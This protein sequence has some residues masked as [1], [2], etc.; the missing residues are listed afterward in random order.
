MTTLLCL[1][2]HGRGK[3]TTIKALAAATGM[4]DR[5]VRDELARLVNE[6]RVPIVTLPTERGI[7]VAQTPEEIDLADQHLKAKAMSLL[8]RRRSLRLCRERLEWSPTLF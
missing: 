7:F 6:A 4:S 2:P 1:L 8:H 3:A 5:A